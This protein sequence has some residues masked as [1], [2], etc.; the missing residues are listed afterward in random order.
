MS[1][2][3]QVYTTTYC[4]YCVRAKKLLSEKGIVY[5]EI[6]LSG[7]DDELVELKNRTG[8]RTVPQIFI[9]E[10]LIGGY[11]ELSALNSSGKLDEL[12]K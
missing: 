1:A 7:R 12:V 9:N 6:N 3:V 11:A 4:P 2:K 8:W 10:K 5:E